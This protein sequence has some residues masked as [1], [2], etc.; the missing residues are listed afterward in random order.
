MQGRDM[1][2]RD[3]NIAEKTGVVGA[4]TGGLGTGF[5]ACHS[6]CQSLISLLAIVGVSVIGMP[7]AFLEPYSI[8]LLLLGL[9]SLGYS[10]WLCKKHHLSLKTLIKPIA[11]GLIIAVFIVLSIFSYT[12]FQTTA[13]DICSPEPGYTEEEWR[14]H[15]SHHPNQFSECLDIK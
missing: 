8:P 2:K 15:M 1:A 5:A 6:V 4:T 13:N 3:R 10:V 11:I 7:L 14:E 9:A 12:A